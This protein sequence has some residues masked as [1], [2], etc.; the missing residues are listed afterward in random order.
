MRTIQSLFIAF[1]AITLLASFS[2]NAQITCDAVYEK[3]M[4]NALAQLDSAQITGRLQ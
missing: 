3:A 4:T 1:F 2:A